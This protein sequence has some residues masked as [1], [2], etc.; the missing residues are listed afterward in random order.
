[1]RNVERCLVTAPPL[2]ISLQSTTSRHRV[3]KYLYGGGPRGL[4]HNTYL[5][6]VFQDRIEN[7]HSLLI[8]LL[9]DHEAFTKVPA[10]QQ[11]DAILG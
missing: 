5:T 11:F 10:G 9:K 8:N 3:H 7:E 4:D 1:M 2:F 6:Q